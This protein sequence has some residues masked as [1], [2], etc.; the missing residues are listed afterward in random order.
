MGLIKEER[1]H[2]R[3]E[4]VE[5]LARLDPDCLPV[6]SIKFNGDGLKER[7]GFHGGCQVKYQPWFSLLLITILCNTWPKGVGATFQINLTSQF[8]P[9]SRKL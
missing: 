6:N 4:A 7:G 2:Q 1:E 5:G 3:G 8:G 9:I